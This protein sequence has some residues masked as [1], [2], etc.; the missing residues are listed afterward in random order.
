M[1]KKKDLII[2]PI[3]MLLLVGVIYYVTT[4]FADEKDV[5]T[6]TIKSKEYEYI[7][8]L[9]YKQEDNDIYYVFIPAGINEDT[10]YIDSNENVVIDNQVVNNFTIE[11]ISYDE[12][13]EVTIKNKNINV[14]FLKADDIPTMFINSNVDIEYVNEKKDRKIDI[15]AY[16]INEDGRA[17]CD[18]TKGTIKGRGNSTWNKA[19]KPYNITFDSKV[20]L[21][22]MGEANKWALLA[23]ALDKSSLNNAIVMNFAH[24]V[25]INNALDCNYVN[26]YINGSYNGLYLLSEK[27]EL[28]DNRI[29][30]S[31]EEV[32][33]KREITE[34]YDKLDN[35]FLTKENIAIEIENARKM[36][37]SEKDELIS[38]VQE[39]EDAIFDLDSNKWKELIDIDSWARVYLIDEVFT[40]YDSGAAS[41]MFS[42]KNDGKFY[43]GPLWDYDFSFEEPN[44]IYANVKYHAPYKER[45]YEYYLMQREEFRQRVFDIFEEE[46]KELFSNETVQFINDEDDRI[47]SSREM[48]S[49]RWDYSTDDYAEMYTGFI[50]NRLNFLDEYFNNYDNYCLVQTDYFN[51]NHLVEKGNTIH[52]AIGFDEDILDDYNFI[53][54]ETSELFDDD[55]EIYDDIS[56]AIQEKSI[57][58]DKPLVL[59]IIGIFIGLI[60][61]LV[62]IGVIHS[63]NSNK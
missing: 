56:L 48:D 19:K 53:N 58:I 1:G 18:K 34:R 52:E 46:Y 20:N 15:S 26:L 36:S 32:L 37:L 16:T 35:A 43:R 7:N 5:E 3:L 23:N 51:Q 21:L 33:F 60:V 40:N 28:A 47:Y 12:E 57:D 8:I 39:M 14:V 27:A 44:L 11:K 9:P 61:L 42:L 17:D 30:L 41:A 4:F 38:K 24:T 13:I 31:D 54:T 63:H 22:N 10:L 50:L 55:T 25:N 2:F 45:I 62:I 6:F 59:G 29:V 49:L